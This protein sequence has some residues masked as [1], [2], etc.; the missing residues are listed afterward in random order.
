MEPIENN[1]DVKSYYTVS[2]ERHCKVVFYGIYT[3]CQLAAYNFC[4]ATEKISQMTAALKLPNRSGR[5]SGDNISKK[6]SKLSYAMGLVEGMNKRVEEE[7]QERKSQRARLAATKDDDAGG[8]SNKDKKPAAK[9]STVAEEDND[10]DSDDESLSQTGKPSAKA[11]LAAEL[12]T[13]R[14]LKELEN[15]QQAAIALADHRGKIEKQVLKDNGIEVTLDAEGNAK[16]KRVY[17][18]P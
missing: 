4:L 3:N 2:R 10:N 7:R 14:R 5:V 11:K 8:V 9:V 6:S 1:F 13:G 12:E 16:G 15:L 18:R 17:P